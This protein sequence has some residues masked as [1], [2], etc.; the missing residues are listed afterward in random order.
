MWTANVQVLMTYNLYRGGADEARVRQTIA[1]G[2]AAR[3]VRLHLPQHP[4]GAVVSWNN[5]AR[6]RQQLPFL[7]EHRLSTS[8]VKV[9][10]SSSSRLASARCWTCWIP[11]T[12]CSMHAVRCSTRS[13][14]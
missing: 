3:D 13:T 10:I 1:Q 7:R 11:R 8:K 5:M 9:A 2:Y 6:L 12:S 4:A 14:T